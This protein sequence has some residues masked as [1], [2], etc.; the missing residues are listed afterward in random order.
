LNTLMSRKET[1]ISRYAAPEDAEEGTIYFHARDGGYKDHAAFLFGELLPV[2]MKR[3]V[4]LKPGKIAVLYPEAWLGDYVA[5]AALEHGF[6]TIRSDKNA[7]Y[8]RSSPLMRWL[9]RCALWCCDGW[10]SG[11][12]RFARITAEGVRMF[13][14]ALSTQEARLA[15]RR[16]L[17]KV[18][19][20]RRDSTASLHNWLRDL[21][22]ELIAPL[23]D[24]SHTLAEEG[25]ALGAFTDRTGPE[26]DVS[27][28]TLGRFA[29]FGEGHD[30]INLSTLHSA[31]GREFEVVFLFGMD[32]GRIPRKKADAIGIKEAR[33]LFYVGFTR[34]ESELHLIFS[35]NN[36]SRFVSEVE[37]RLAE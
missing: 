14:E 29:G 21:H 8:P 34:T 24:G 6:G 35:A 9:E 37:R 27:E 36:P 26:G 17:I 1:G 23:L 13:A 28:M 16:K 22:K 7:L 31:K 18:L 15:F 25:E 20:D 11:K 33:R 10:R 5:E 32:E 19:W 12:P 30:R 3:V 2:V 4:D